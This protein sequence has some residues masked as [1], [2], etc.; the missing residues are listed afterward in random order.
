[1]ASLWDYSQLDRTRM[2]ALTAPSFLVTYAQTQFLLAEAVVRKWAAGDAVA[3]YA[4]GIRAH[5]QQF[6]MYGASTVIG[7]AAIGT[8][9][10]AHPL[11]AGKELEDINTQYWVASFLIGRKHL[12]TSAAVVPGFKTQSIPR[13]RSQIRTVYPPANLYRRRTEC[14]P[15]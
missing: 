2:A 8:Y 4:E 7:D 10:A 15:R 12:L 1:L 3:L 5:M 14:K 11:R 9:V 13:Q 6:A